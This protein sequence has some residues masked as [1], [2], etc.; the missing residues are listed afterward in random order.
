MWASVTSGYWSSC[1]LNCHCAL[2]QEERLSKYVSMRCDKPN[3]D[4][5][6]QEFPA[7]R[8]I[9]LKDT[10]HHTDLKPLSARGC[11][12]A[13]ISKGDACFSKMPVRACLMTRQG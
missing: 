4:R 3:I 8:H 9:S 11:R 12:C 1:P 2:L 10:S 5:G 7:C 6:C 13:S